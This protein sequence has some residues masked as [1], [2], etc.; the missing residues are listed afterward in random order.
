[1]R[2][3][4]DIKKPTLSYRLQGSVL[5][6]AVLLSLIHDLSKNKGPV[7]IFYYPFS[8]AIYHEL[9]FTNIFKIVHTNSNLPHKCRQ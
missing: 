8:V 1:M 3:L 6:N 2:A 5:K 7:D 4:K 9:V